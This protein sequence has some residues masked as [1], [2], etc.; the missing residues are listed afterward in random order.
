MFLLCFDM[1][2]SIK[3]N[4]VTNGVVKRIKSLNSKSFHMFIT[5]CNNFRAHHLHITAPENSPNTDGIHV[6]SSNM[7]RIA[8]SVIGTG[9]DCISIG[10]GSTNVLI[11]KVQCG[12]GHGIR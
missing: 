10:Q 3:F 11:N 12:P 2:Q 8:R 5:N 1:V 7:V 6:S 4:K 9:D